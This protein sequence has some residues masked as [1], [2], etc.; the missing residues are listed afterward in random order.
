MR[1]FSP[2]SPD[3]DVAA[4]VID[5]ALEDLERG[6][7]HTRG[8][9]PSESDRRDAHRFIYSVRLAQSRWLDALSDRLTVRDIRRAADRAMERRRAYI[10][11][12][13]ALARDRYAES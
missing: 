5:R 7:L 3:R 11:R 2:G 10:V 6:G 1:Q 12:R 8:S 9:G 4:A 13:R